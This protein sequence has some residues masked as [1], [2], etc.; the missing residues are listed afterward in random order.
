MPKIK[1]PLEKLRDKA[2]KLQS[3]YVR[4]FYADWRG[5]VRCFTCLAIRHYKEMQAGHYKHKYLDFDMRNIHPQCDS[6]NRWAYGKAPEYKRN[7]VFTYGEEVLKEIDSGVKEE[8]IRVEKLGYAYTTEEL[9][10]IIEDLKE[11]IKCLPNS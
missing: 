2:W 5:W 6:C 10:Q 9:N 11:K 8:K 1:T 3:E 4:R 7:L